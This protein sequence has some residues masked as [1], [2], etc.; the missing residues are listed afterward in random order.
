MKQK[1]FLCLLA[2]TSFFTASSQN[3]GLGNTAGIGMLGDFNNWSNDV[4]MSTT[5]NE[6]YT[7]SAYTFTV[8]GNV[9]FRMNGSWDMNWG[10]STFPTGDAV[11]NGGNILVVRQLKTK[12]TQIDVLNG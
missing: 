12:T 5:D 2:L 10:G 7:I 4:P 6:N 11:S 1:L 9:K 8:T 3:V